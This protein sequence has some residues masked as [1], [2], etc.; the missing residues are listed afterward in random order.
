MPFADGGEDFEVTGDSKAARDPHFFKRVD[1]HAD[2]AVPALAWLE[3]VPDEVESWR[4][5][6]P[7]R[8]ALRRSSGEGFVTNLC[9]TI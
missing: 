5:S 2:P 3:S 8:P 4:Q 1:P 6:T 9:V 7:L